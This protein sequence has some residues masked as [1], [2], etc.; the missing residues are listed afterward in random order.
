MLEYDF[1][2]LPTNDVIF[3]YIFSSENSEKCLLPFLNAILQDAGR[4]RI[5]SVRIRNPFSLQKFRGDK[6]V[7]LD[8]CATDEK[9]RTFDIEIQ[10]YAETAFINRMLYYWSRMY[11]GQLASGEDYHRLRP[12]ISIVLTRFQLFRELEEMHNVFNITAEKDPNFV[13]TRDFQLHTLELTAS[14]WAHFLKKYEKEHGADALE[15]HSLRNWLDFLL[16]CHER[17]EAEMEN[18]VLNTEGLD[19]AVEKLHSAVSDTEM[20]ELAFAYEKSAR[21]ERARLSFAR[22]QGIEQG[23]GIGIEQGIEQ[24]ELRAKRESVLALLKA[25][26]PLYFTGLEVSA[27]SQIEDPARLDR[28]FE[29]ALAGMPFEEL[30]RFWEK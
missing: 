16:H 14:K 18:M 17:T 5:T 30:K 27:L 13:L 21:D 29:S 3:Q 26:Y 24:G 23:I 15:K 19:A 1:E 11:S 28:I 6:K 2:L 10:T 4:E 12:A 25:F 7:V 8:I 22:Q 9:D 20:R